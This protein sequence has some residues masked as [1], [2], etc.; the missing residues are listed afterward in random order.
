MAS[1]SYLGTDKGVCRLEGDTLEPLGLEEYRVSAIYATRAG[2]GHDLILAGTY[3]DGMYRSTDSGQTWEPANEGMTA[4]AFRTIQADPTTPGALI[5]GA[6]P[7]R[8]FRTTD[9]GQSW[10]GMAAIKEIESSPEWY[11]PYSP[12]AGALRNFYSPPGQ[13]SRLL[14]AVEVGGLLESG[15]AGETWRLIPFEPDDDFHYVTGHPKNDELL[16]VALGWASLERGRDRAGDNPLGGVARSEN[17]GK[18]WTKFHA[19]YTRAVIVPP[20]NDG[21]LLAAPAQKVG[22]LGRIEVSADGGEHWEDAGAG[23]EAPMEDMVELFV[24]APDGT[25]CAV[26]SGGRLLVS[27]PGPWQWRSLLP[28]GAQ[29]A[30]EAISFVNSVNGS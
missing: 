17:G 21:L 22:Q 7:A 15:D 26:C 12:R 24:P 6:E 2:N 19:D 13:P 14:G 8:A 28:D 25:I 1:H 10:H 18:S 27:E 11:L 29:V 16:Y 5:C 9:G 4:S 20:A 3:G 30:V 23:L